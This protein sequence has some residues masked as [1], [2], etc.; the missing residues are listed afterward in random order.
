MEGQGWLFFFKFKLKPVYQIMLSLL[1]NDLLSGYFEL[2]GRIYSRRFPLD[3][4]KLRPEIVKMIL[5]S[6]HMVQHFS[7]LDL[8]SMDSI[9]EFATEFRQN[10]TRLDVL[11]NNAGIMAVPQGK[12]QVSIAYLHAMLQGNL[13]L[14]HLR[15]RGVK[16]WSLE[17]IPQLFHI[18]AIP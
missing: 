17:A 3:G 9:R 18:K 11:I 6:Y 12:T 14:A 4:W 5:T 8:S 15:Q 7:T 1:K 16:I 2:C 10:E 13:D